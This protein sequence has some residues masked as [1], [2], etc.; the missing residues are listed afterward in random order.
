MNIAAT[1]TLPEVTSPWTPFNYDA[2]PTPHP[3]QAI[4]NFIQH[5][6]FAEVAQ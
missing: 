6:L 4:K 3:S 1:W 5:H 2:A